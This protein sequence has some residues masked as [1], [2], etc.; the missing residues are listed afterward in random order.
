MNEN[1]LDTIIGTGFLSKNFNKY[2]EFFKELNICVYAAGVSNSLCKDSELFEK[3]K[4]RLYDFSNKINI[5]EDKLF[6]IQNDKR[7]FVRSLGIRSQQLR[8]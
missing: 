7:Q 1:P 2:K 5:L 3:E 4:K 8:I 6:N